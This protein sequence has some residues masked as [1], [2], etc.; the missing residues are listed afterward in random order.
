MSTAR[1]YFA[2]PSLLLPATAALIIAAPARADLPEVAFG[3]VFEQLCDDLRKAS[4]CT[5]C[6]CQ[7]VTSTPLDG[8][9]ADAD[10][11]LAHAFIVKLESPPPE[12][13]PGEPFT[14]KVRFHLAVGSDRRLEPA[15]LL[16]GRD[17]TPENIAYLDVEL[18]RLT[19]FH[20]LCLKCDHENAGLVHLLHVTL[21]EQRLEDRE[22]FEVWELNHDRDVL[23]ACYKKESLDCF[24]TP[25]GETKQENRQPQ[26]PGD[27][28]VKG[29]K[30]SWS[31]T[32]KIG[33]RN[34]MEVVLGPVKGNLAKE[35]KAALGDD[36]S[37]FNFTDLPIRKSATKLAR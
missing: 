23:V 8:V 26:A 37:T 7:P 12:V 1:T 5:D 31:R 17:S 22:N 15:G 27:K 13:G 9:P 10:P 19:R 33:G 16:L 21:K 24:S 30:Q 6:R 11:D 35:A 34:Q 14:H 4:D 25:L 18:R 28:G 29:R 36:A 32:W 20:D 2:L 3:P